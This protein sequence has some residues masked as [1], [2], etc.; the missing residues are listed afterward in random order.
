MNLIFL[1]G[2]P[3]A[4]KLTIAKELVKLVSYKLY[5]NHAIIS[6][7]GALFT[8]ADPELNAIRAPPGKRIR[9]DD[10]GSAAKAGINFISTSGGVGRKILSFFVNYNVQLKLTVA[11]RCLYKFYQRKKRYYLELI[12]HPGLAIRP[13][14]KCYLKKS[15]SKTPVSLKS[16]L[17]KTT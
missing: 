17:I 15:Y 8:Y 3:A 7:L 1:Y 13:I 9:V 14:Q 10:F 5:D 16:F 2:T 4:G 6:P 12:N 11:P